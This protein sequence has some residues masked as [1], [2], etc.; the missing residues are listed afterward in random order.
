[1]KRDRGPNKVVLLLGLALLVPFLVLFAKSFGNDPRAVPF[2]L[3]GKPAPAFDLQ[4][5]DGAPISLQ[6]LKG[7]KVVLNFWS[8]WCIPCKQEHALL[9]QGPA[10]YP[11]VTFLGV[12]YQDDEN[13]ARH[14]L[15]REGATYQHLVDPGG[16]VAVRYG[17]AGV[18]ETY[19]IDEQGTLVYKQV[20][21]LNRMTMPALIN[22]H[23][24]G[25]R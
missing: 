2:L 5:L 14:Y 25:G 15:R 16:I 23:L 12:V 8:T 19:F 4:T 20:G 10:D 3:E 22:A 11:D 18:P 1:M 9:Q 13:K 24:G 7:K 17:V 6:S 21:P